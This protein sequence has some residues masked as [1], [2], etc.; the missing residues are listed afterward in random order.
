VS[1]STVAEGPAKPSIRERNR[2]RVRGR[3]YDAA[4]ELFADRPYGEVTVGEICE[5]AEVARA[6]FFR[7]FGT[8]AGL[9]DEFNARLTA[10]VQARLAATAGATATE[11][12]WAIEDE[13]TTA[14]GHSSAATREMARE[15]IRNATAADLASPQRSAALV[16]LVADVV[17]EGQRSGEFR[18]RHQP[19]FVASMIVGALSV[20]TGSWLGREDDAG[21]ADV[22]RQA[23]ELLLD[24]LRSSEP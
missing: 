17:R 19:T 21:P 23:I 2:S 20:A 6:T 12:L 11:R 15:W 10:A 8:K 7:S 24:G 13:I 18:P 5:R 1:L 3:L 16:T 4:L 22:S 9:L 14:W